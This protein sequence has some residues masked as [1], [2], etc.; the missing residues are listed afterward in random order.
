MYRRLAEPRVR[1]LAAKMGWSF[2]EALGAMMS[3]WGDS[4]AAGLA[5]GTREEIIFWTRAEDRGGW[6]LLFEALQARAIKFISPSETPGMW[7]IHGNTDEIDK[8]SKIKKA[9]SDA[10]KVRW[11]CKP[12]ANASANAMH[13]D[14]KEIQTVCPFPS[15]PYPLLKEEIPPTFTPPHCLKNKQDEELAQE[16]ANFAK[17]VSKTVRPN[18]AKWT[19]T[20]RLLR[21]KDGLTHETLRSILAFVHSDHFWQHNAASL[22][23]LRSRSKNG[24]RKFENILAAMKQRSTQPNK[25]PVVEYP[26]YTE[27]DLAKLL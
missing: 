23:G 8:V 11:G 3:L 7:K 10:A 22:E 21:E 6:D 24:L 25:K 2:N 4:Q 17:E 20:V 14:A 12:D 27:A 18:E 1:L 19:D 16:W 15:L 9:R 13:V 5:E 26:V